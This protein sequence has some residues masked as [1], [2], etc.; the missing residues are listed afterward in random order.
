ME[1]PSARGAVRDGDKGN[2]KTDISERTIQC[3]VPESTISTASDSRIAKRIRTVGHAAEMMADTTP[4]VQGE[5]RPVFNHGFAV[6]QLVFAGV[7]GNEVSLC[8]M[9]GSTAVIHLDIQKE[10]VDLHIIS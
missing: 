8:S 1:N 2:R 4:V 7:P 5:F 6:A 9:A 10:Y 3:V